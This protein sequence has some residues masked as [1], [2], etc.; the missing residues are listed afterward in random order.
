MIPT[1]RDNQT[2]VII[3]ICQGEAP[4]FSESEVLGILHLT[5]L[6]PAPRGDTKIAVEFIMDAN[7]I[8]QV[9]ARDIATGQ[10]TAA[11]LSVVGLGS[12]PR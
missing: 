4:R 3:R 8:L 7:G 2:E 10:Q 5:N 12:A 1:V 11:T 6:R 9:S